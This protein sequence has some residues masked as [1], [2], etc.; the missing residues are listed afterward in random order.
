MPDRSQLLKQFLNLLD[1]I[2]G[3]EVKTEDIRIILRNGRVLSMEIKIEDKIRPDLTL[4]K[5][6]S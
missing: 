1:K 2:E 3:N 4:I 5:R 6:D